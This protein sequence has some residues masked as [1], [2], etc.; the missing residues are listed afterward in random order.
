MKKMSGHYA[1]LLVMNKE[2]FRSYIKVR[3]ALKVKPKTIY[4]EL[5]SVYTDQTLSNSTVAKRSE[6]FHEGRETVEDKLRPGRSVTETKPAN[7]EEIRRLINDDPHLM[8][9]EIQAETCMSHGTTERIISDH[10]KLKN[11]SSMKE[12]NNS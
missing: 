1:L 2:N 6:W 7:I 9:D 8:I 12:R 10:L 3:I 11:H 4:D 5:Y